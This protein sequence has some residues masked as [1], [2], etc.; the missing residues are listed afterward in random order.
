MALVDADYKFIWVDIGANDPASDAA[1]FNHSEMKEV[2]ENGT[3][4][5]PAADPLPNDN[6]PMPYFIIPSHNKVVEGI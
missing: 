1:N 2:I 4:G 3:I 5:F 6:R